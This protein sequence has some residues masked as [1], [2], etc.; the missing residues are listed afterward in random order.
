[1]V[2]QGPPAAGPHVPHRHRRRVAS[3]TTRRSR[4]TL[5]GRAPLRRV[6][7][8]RASSSS[9]DLPERGPRRVQP[10]QRAAPPAAVRLHPRGA[11]DHHRPDGAEGHRAARLDGH[12]HADRR[13]VGRGPACCS[14][15]SPSSSPRSPT[16]RSTPSARRSSRRSRRR[17]GRRPTCS[18]PGPESCRQLALPFPIIDNDE[19]A[20]IVHANDGGQFPGLRSYVVEGPVPRRRRRAGARAGAGGDLRRG[21]GG[22]RGRRPHHRAVGPQRRRGRGPDPVAAAHRRRAPPPRAHQ[23]AHHGRAARR[24]RRR[25]RGAPHGAAHRLRR[26]RH[27]PVPGVRVD[28]GPDRRGHATGSA[29]IDPAKAMRNYIKACGK[30]VLKVMSKMGVSTVASYTGAQIFEAIGL[31]DELVE[32]YFTGTVSRLGGIG[33]DEIAIEVAARHAQRPPERA[34]RSGPTAS[35]SSAASTSG[36]ARARSTCSTRRRCSSCS[37]PRGPSAT[38]S[39]S[40]TPE[41]VDDQS[42]RLATL[43]GLFDLQ[44]GERA[45]RSRSTR[46]SRSRRSSGGSRP[47]P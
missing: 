32:Q 33:L 21:H 27:Q 23:A 17:S 30:G 35:S 47:A 26:R 42:K 31:G 15:T 6:A 1:M 11:Q 13:A 19:L 14:T 28:R 20:K 43:R 16:R 9:E 12:R 8:R 3:S 10:R 45:R 40:S 24:V 36:A 5:A 38:T 2:T 4:P 46:S 41:L 22:H 37:T 25:P 39:S 29:A 7:R 44:V 34:R 18:R